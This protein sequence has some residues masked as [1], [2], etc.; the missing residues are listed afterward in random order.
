MT[1]MKNKLLFHSSKTESSCC[2]VSFHDL[3]SESKRLASKKLLCFI[4][5]LH[6]VFAQCSKSLHSNTFPLNWMQ[7][8]MFRCCFYIIWFITEHN[9]ILLRL[10]GNSTMPWPFYTFPQ[11]VVDWADEA[12][13]LQSQYPFWKRNSVFSP[14]NTYGACQSFHGFKLA[15]SHGKS[16]CYFHD[17]CNP[18]KLLTWCSN[19]KHNLFIASLCIF[20]FF[21]LPI[22]ITVYVHRA[23]NTH[24]YTQWQLRGQISACVI[25]TLHQSELIV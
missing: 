19:G 6:F 22:L 23:L 25:S 4:R 20:I 24:Q 13:S 5:F 18:L 21:L 14:A 16:G 1:E 2:F 8:K 9:E 7:H 17:W 3:W 10:G 15:A 11:W 12:Q